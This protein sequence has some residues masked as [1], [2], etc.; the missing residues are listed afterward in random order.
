MYTHLENIP[1]V[2][3]C[4]RDKLVLMKNKLALAKES[5]TIILNLDRNMQH[6][7]VLKMMTRQLIVTHINGK[8]KL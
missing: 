8:V 2:F 5:N 4:T 1:F 6:K 3:I 7:V